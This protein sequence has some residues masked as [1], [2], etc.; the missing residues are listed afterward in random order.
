M[1]SCRAKVARMFPPREA[2]AEFNIRGEGDQFR[3]CLG[4]I[5]HRGAWRICHGF[6]NAID[7]NAPP[8]WRPVAD[9]SVAERVELV[10]H[11]PALRDAIV[12]EAEKSVTDVRKAVSKL[13]ESIAQL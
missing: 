10:D 1:V 12:A 7:D 13:E 8:S 4:L 6:Y 11:L 2:W 3:E 9:C 5:K